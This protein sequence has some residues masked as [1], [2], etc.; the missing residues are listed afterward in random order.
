VSLAQILTA[1]SRKRASFNGNLM[2]LL[3]RRRGETIWLP[4]RQEALSWT[5]P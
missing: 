5:F 1:V 2:T 4:L 3:F